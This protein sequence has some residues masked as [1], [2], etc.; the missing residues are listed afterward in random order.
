MAFSKPIGILSFFLSRSEKQCEKFGGRF[1]CMRGLLEP[2]ICRFVE[3][4]YENALNGL[5]IEEDSS[6]FQPLEWY[7][8]SSEEKNS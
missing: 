1:Q 7:F 2:H 8:L 6:F 4:L 5:N 3:E